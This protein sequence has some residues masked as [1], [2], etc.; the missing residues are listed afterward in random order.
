MKLRLVI[1]VL[2]AAG[3]ACAAGD[4][5][6]F[7][8]DSGPPYWGDAAVERA[9][10]SIF[11]CPEVPTAYVFDHADPFTGVE[12]AAELLARAGFQVQPLPMTDTPTSLRGLIFFA[13]FA[14]ES[15]I[16]RSY[17]RSNAANL[18]TFVDGGNVLVQM[19]QAD[20]TEAVAPFLP[21][22]Y[23]ARRS[24]LDLGRLKVLDP[25][26]PLLQGV[27]TIDGYLAW[28]GA[29][30]GWETFVSQGGFA[31]SLAEDDVGH[32]AA[33]L[34]AAYG[35][36]RIILTAMAFDKPLGTAPG[37]VL[38]P[39]AIGTAE[40]R[41]AFNQ[42][43]FAN[44]YQHVKNVCRRQTKELDVTPSSPHP[45]FAADSFMLAVLPDT[46]FYSLSY[47]GIYA[48]QTSWIAANARRRHIP[49]VLHLGDIVNNNSPTEW[50]RAYES[51]SL[52]DGVVPYALSTGNH[53]YGPSGDATTRETLLN[54]YFPFQKQAALPSFGG[55]F[56]AGKLDNTFHLFSAGGR[57][58]VL[59]SLEWGPRD[60]AVDWANTVMDRYPDRQGILITH[61]YM[62]NNDRR[63]DWADQANPQLYDPHAYGT[64]GGVNDGE[65]LWQ[66][67]V[68]HHRF[69]LTLNGHVLGDGTGYLASV[70]D[71]G[72]TCHQILSNYQFRNLGGEGYMRLMEFLHDGKTVRVYTYSPFYDDYLVEPDQKFTFTL[73]LPPTR[74]PP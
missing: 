18:Y 13:S 11:N 48:A 55:A 66:K 56:E 7:D 67:L 21:T 68:R 16:Y 10:P 39:T 15:E 2:V 4:D 51:M 8:P 63:Y 6:Q 53:D 35:Q 64:P 17:V 70:T 22:G 19:T 72:N 12:G 46:Q 40:A 24:D 49:Y 28:E 37:P 41:D 14:S 31:N 61:A 45:L 20:Q 54:D 32:N 47:P 26:Y 52:L 44:L 42:V 30:I 23:Q 33:F 73:D 69:V 58:F 1:M 59:V 71:L 62:N 65:E 5:G 3:G 9:D 25:G 50:E 57:D 29:R 74:P 36:G 34:E 60:A 43:F 38:F 27:P